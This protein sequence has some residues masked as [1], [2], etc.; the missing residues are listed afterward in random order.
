MHDAMV[1]RGCKKSDCILPGDMGLRIRGRVRCAAGDG[2]HGDIECGEWLCDTEAPGM[3]PLPYVQKKVK[4][5][6]IKYL[7]LMRKF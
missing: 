5:N 7:E 2:K 6:F 4:R 3:L 1:Q